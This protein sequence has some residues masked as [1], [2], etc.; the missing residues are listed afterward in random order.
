MADSEDQQMGEGADGP[1]GTGASAPRARPTRRQPPP[2]NGAAAPRQVERAAAARPAKRTTPA[3]ER[4]KASADPT[5][6]PVPASRQEPGKVVRPKTGEGQPARPRAKRPTTVRP[7]A[8]RPPSV[9]SGTGAKVDGRLRPKVVPTGES[10]AP[11]GPGADS[12]P[13]RKSQRPPGATASVRLPASTR[14]GS[15]GHDERARSGERAGEQGAEDRQP[16]GADRPGKARS[17]HASAGRCLAV[18]LVCFG[19]WL[20]FDANQL[21]L[22][23]Q[24][25]PFG[26][27]RTVA[28]DIL[29]PMAW[30]S[31]ILSASS[32]VDGAND[33]LGRQVSSASNQNYNPPVQPTQTT[34]PGWYGPG[35]VPFGFVPHDIGHVHFVAPPPS[36]SQPQLAAITQPSAAHPLRV[37]EIGDS[38]GEDFGFG[39]LDQYGGDPYVQMYAE[40]QVDT[41]LADPGYF[42]WPQHLETYLH[43]YHPQVVIVM[44]GGND[45]GKN[46][47]QFNQL[48]N[49]GTPLWRVDY[50]ERVAQIMSEATS[51]GAHVFWVGMPIMGDPGLSSQ[52]V[53]QNGVYAAQAKTHPGVSFFSCWKLFAPNGKY[54]SYISTPGGLIEARYPD[55]THIAPGGGDY[56]AA[57]V[58]TAMQ[59]MWHV[60]LAP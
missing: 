56:L 31:N 4:A 7:D 35:G 12:V 9:G 19:V 1:N 54:T 29:R 20:L 43:R 17:R 33:A 48:A 13:V 11:S 10:Q 23:A 22:S 50:G 8:A 58:N 28:I 49:Y 44:L 32:F 59:R 60:K 14:P 5:V 38:V 47:V 39:L 55:Q 2:S 41:G 53:L 26:A 27:R 42:N 25:Q 36:Q 6:E 45:A 52:M 46:L 24:Q 40:A 15:S 21:Y 37:L 18:G 34:A 16:R 3:S 51:A 30:V 57:A